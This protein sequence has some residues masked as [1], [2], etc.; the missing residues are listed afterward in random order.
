MVLYPFFDPPSLWRKTLKAHTQPLGSLSALSALEP[1]KCY[2]SKA[3]SV[4]GSE[5]SHPFLVVYLS[6]KIACSL[7]SIATSLTLVHQLHLIRGIGCQNHSRKSLS[8]LPELTTSATWPNL[9][10]FKHPVLH[11]PSTEYTL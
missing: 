11:P 2:L 4:L 5:S 8:R 9:R 6:G 7:G 3:G 10:Y 1:R